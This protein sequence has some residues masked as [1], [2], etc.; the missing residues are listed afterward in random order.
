MNWDLLIYPWTWTGLKAARLMPFF[1]TS[2]RNS[3]GQ[4]NL[5]LSPIKKLDDK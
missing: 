5:K 3:Y 2:Y 1:E 4:K